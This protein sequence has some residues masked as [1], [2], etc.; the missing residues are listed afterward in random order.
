MKCPAEV[1]KASTKPYRGIGEPH[2]PFHDK[3]IVVTHCGRLCLYRKKINLSTCMARPGCGNQGSRPRYLAPQLYGYD[4]GYVDLEEKTFQPLKNPFGPKG[5]LCLR[6]NLLPMCPV[7]TSLD[8]APQVGFEPT[9][10]RIVAAT[11][12]CQGSDFHSSRATALWKLSACSATAVRV[13]VNKQAFRCYEYDPLTFRCPLTK[14]R[15]AGCA[16]LPERI[17]RCRLTRAS[18]LAIQTSRRQSLLAF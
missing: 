8:L 10:L 1:Y 6:N 3:T 12:M 14:F 11:G 18:D 9:T 16:L 15:A 13:R 5:Y 4:L 7:R 17:L 2:Y